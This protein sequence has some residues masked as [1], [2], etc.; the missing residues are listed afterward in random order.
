[1]WRKSGGEFVGKSGETGGTVETHFAQY[2]YGI[3]L[4]PHH[5]NFTSADRS[6]MAS[7]RAWNWGE[8]EGVRNHSRHVKGC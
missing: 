2:S 3:A 1:M 4:A 5:S 8:E 6:H 7:C